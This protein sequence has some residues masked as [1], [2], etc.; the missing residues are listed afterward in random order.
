MKVLL[1]ANVLLGLTDLEHP[2]HAVTVRALEVLKLQLHELVLVPQVVY[3]WWEKV[4]LPKEATGL[5][6]TNSIAG[7]VFR[8]F[9]SLFPTLPDSPLLMERWREEIAWNLVTGEGIRH[10]RLVTA[11][12]LA[13]AGA[14]LTFNV[15]HY[16]RFGLPLLDPQVVAESSEAVA[17]ASHSG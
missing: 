3:E 8:S 14:L 13:G 15:H 4:T 10:A 11:G 17:S 16:E 9:D 1:D 5:G 7:I 2:H 12:T 6:Y